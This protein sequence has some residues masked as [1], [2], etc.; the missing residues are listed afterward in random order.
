MLGRYKDAIWHY[1]RFLDR[2]KPAG[3]GEASVKKVIA[4]MKGELEKAAMKQPP[5]ERA[6]SSAVEARSPR[7]GV[8]EG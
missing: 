8:T 4:E 7:R 2:G 5:I 3:E 6:S 1:E